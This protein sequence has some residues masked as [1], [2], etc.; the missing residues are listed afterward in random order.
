MIY[1][2]PVNA[3]G[4]M[5]TRNGDQIAICNV[6]QWLRKE[7][8]QPTIKFFLAPGVLNKE[9][10]I[11]KFHKFLLENTDYFSAEPGKEL[12]D[13][14]NVGLFDFRDVIGD[15]VIINNNR[16]QQK[17]VVIFPL[18]D[19]PYNVQRN[20]TV[21][22]LNRILNECRTKYPDHKKYICAKELPPAGLI[23]TTGFELSTDF[24]TNIEHIMEAEV[25][26][27]GD[28]GVSH[29]ASVLNPG[30][31]K[32]NYIYSSR[33]FIHTLPF[34]FISENKGTLKT[35]HLPF[36]QEERWNIPK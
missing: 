24:I 28:T 9:D 36:F 26:Y 25:F 5:G 23:D 4:Y 19:A 8:N 32:L 33:S 12:L 7:K 2:V 6:I 17:K 21:D 20:W 27:G 18:Y 29:F 35:Y 3:F 1:N 22:E 10:Y 31:K 11:H 14:N 34:Y 15:H 13:W 16:T 30:P